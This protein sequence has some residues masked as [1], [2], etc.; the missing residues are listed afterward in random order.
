MCVVSVCFKYFSSF[1]RML[2]MFHLDV[3]HVAVAIHVC[4]KSVFQMFRLFHLDVAYFYLDVA[5]VVVAIHICCKYMFQMCHLFHTYVVN[6]LSKC[7]IC[8]SDYTYMLQAYVSIVSHGFSI[9]QQMLL[10][11]TLTRGHARVTH[12][13]PTLFISVMRASFNS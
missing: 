6:I 1:K 5:Y 8:Y 10:P 2:Q 12:T 7:C 13:H 9:L 4:C 3:A 11:R